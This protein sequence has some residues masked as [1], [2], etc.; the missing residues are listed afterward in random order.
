MYFDYFVS[1]CTSGINS[2]KMFLAYKDV[3]MLNDQELYQAMKKC[4]DI[5]ALAQVHA[6]NGDLIAEV[7]EEC[8][9]IEERRQ[10]TKHNFTLLFKNIINALLIYF[11]VYI[12]YK[13]VLIYKREYDNY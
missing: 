8:S 3:F 13:I 2:F 12:S 11:L 6:E 10:A 5:G 7:C 1:P 4:K 9:L